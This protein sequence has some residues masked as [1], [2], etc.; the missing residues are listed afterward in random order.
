M[1]EGAGRSREDPHR[2]AASGQVG[3]AE[4]PKGLNAESAEDAEKAL[5]IT[6]LSVFPALCFLFFPTFPQHAADLQ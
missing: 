4:G 2:T 6:V 3:I 1:A 5:R